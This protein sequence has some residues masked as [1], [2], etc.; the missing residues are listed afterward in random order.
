MTMSAWPQLENGLDCLTDGG[1]ETTLIFHDGFELPAFSSAH[2]LGTGEGRRHLRAYYDGYVDLAERF[3]TGFVLESP[4]WR[5]SLDWA[6]ALGINPA[7]LA[8]RNRDAITLLHEI[9]EARGQRVPMV[10]SGCVGP[11][12]DGYRPD[13][14]MTAD[15]ATAYHAWQIGHLAAAGVDVISGVTVPTV[16]EA[17]GIARAAAAKGLPSVIS[18]TV[19]T[20][21]CLP[22]GEALG[23]AIAA[24]D[25]ATTDGAPAYY[26]VNCAHPSHFE[27][28]LA[29]PVARD[30][31]RGLR[32]N[33]SRCSHA[34]LDEATELDDGDPREFGEEHLA[35]L[36]RSPAI[37]ILGGCC[38]T[39]LRH[40]EAIAAAFSRRV[41][42]R[43]SSR[44]AG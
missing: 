26:M 37:H 19:E 13:A 35:L 29:E 40:V 21:G 18:F 10:V 1:L 25:A 32:A 44:L 7:A 9:R 41:S 5:A 22:T 33:A 14:V 43:W 16:P 24:V 28:A 38:G 15:E 4:T 30:R 6:P 11:R 27:T 34:E 23:D 2:L 8:G 42:G 20:D 31:V 39:D 36:E 3:G 12:G 17:T